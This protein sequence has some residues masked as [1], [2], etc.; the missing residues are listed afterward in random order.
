MDATKDWSRVLALSKK[1][2]AVVPSRRHCDA[3]F[4]NYE[5]ANKTQQVALE[6]ARKFAGGWMQDDV[7][8][9]WLL[10]PIGTGKTHLAVSILR[11]CIAED[12]NDG[13]DGKYAFA[14]WHDIVDE[15]RQWPKRDEGAVR[16]LVDSDLLV[17][18]DL[19]VCDERTAAGFEWVVDRRYRQ[20]RPIVLTS[21]LDHQSIREVVGHRAFDRLREGAVLR[22]LQ[23]ASYRAR[24]GWDGPAVEA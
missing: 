14:D 5:V 15:L 23:G 2:A 24:F 22:V 8:G 17:V 4:E 12:L 16:R 7:G 1:L 9:L 3:S 20:R 21:N 18:D 13:Y 6:A 10:G 19:Q 11:T